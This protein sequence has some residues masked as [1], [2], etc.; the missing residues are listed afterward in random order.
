MK[1]HIEVCVGVWTYVVVVVVVV[2]VVEVV[3]VVGSSR[4]KLKFYITFP[5]LRVT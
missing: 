1:L 5:F 2:V 3:V 4:H